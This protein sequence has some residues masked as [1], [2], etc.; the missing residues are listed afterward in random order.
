MQHYRSSNFG[1]LPPAIKNILIINVIFY[2]ATLALGYRGIDL[3]GM[4]ALYYPMAG[5][6]RPYQILSHFFMHGGLMHIFVN[7]FMLWMFGRMLE[8]VWGG[9]RFLLFY[10]ITAFGAAALHYGVV[11]YNIHQIEAVLSAEQISQV[12]NG[13]LTGMFNAKM[14][15]LY[16]LVNTPMLGASGAVFGVLGACFIIFPNTEV[17]LLFFPM[18]IKLKYFVV[19]YA[20]LEFTM[21]IS[22]SPYDNV[23]H[24]AHL[25]GLLA[26]IIVVKYWNKTRRDRFF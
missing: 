2:L 15:E 9:K 16:R 7:M 12:Y 21:G 25:G 20:V 19:G 10:L 23:A 13:S 17:M 4:L 6:F 24:W 11:Y 26:G 18:P 8:I 3:R 5:E 1:Q 22:N 14:V